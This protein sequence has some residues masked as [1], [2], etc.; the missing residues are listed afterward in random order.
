[1]NL[2]LD[3]NIAVDAERF[4]LKMDKTDFAVLKKTNVKE[5]K[6][7]KKELWQ[8]RLLR[9]KFFLGFSTTHGIL[10]FLLFPQHFF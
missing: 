4:N 7:L 3:E 6:T 2:Y 8:Y 9:L 1:M 5:W 10:H